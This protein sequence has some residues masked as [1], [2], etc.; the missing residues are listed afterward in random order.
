[1]NA[2]VQTGPETL[3][4]LKLNRQIFLRVLAKVVQH[5]HAFGVRVSRGFVGQSFFQPRVRQSGQWDTAAFGLLFQS[6]IDFRIK[7]DAMWGSDFEL[8]FVCLIPM[9]SEAMTIPVVTNL[10]YRP[11]N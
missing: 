7:R 4:Q 5:L 10:F 3:K 8:D 1:V 2:A 11:R 9:I 6:S